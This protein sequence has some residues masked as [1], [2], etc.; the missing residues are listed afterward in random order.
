[1]TQEEA[2]L[3]LSSYKD[4]VEKAPIYII[5]ID[6]DYRITYANETFFEDFGYRRN[7]TLGL[8]ANEMGVA[9]EAFHKW[10]MYYDKV[11]LTGE[12]QSFEA[13]IEGPDGTL[14]FK[15]NLIPV[16]DLNQKVES[17]TIYLSN[18]TDSK[19][20]EDERDY[21]FNFSLDMF[22]VQT[23]E[24]NFIRLNPSWN[25]ILNLSTEKLTGANW[26]DFVHPDD[27]VRSEN[28]RNE[29]LNYNI[30]VSH[31]TRFR[32]FD[33]TYLWLEW[34]SIPIKNKDIIISVVRDITNWKEI[35]D[36]LYESEKRYREVVET[37]NYMIYSTDLKGNMELMNN[38]GLNISGFDFDELQGTNLLDLIAPDYREKIRKLYK[39]MIEKNQPTNIIE[40]PI[41]SKS[42]E[43]LWLTQNAKLRVENGVP[44]KIDFIARDITIRKDAELKLR[45]SE[46]RLRNVVNSSNEV[47]L[48]I[49]ECGSLKDANDTAYEELDIVEHELLGKEFK[50]ILF[51]NESKELISNFL[52]KELDLNSLNGEIRLKLNGKNP[53]HYRAKAITYSD[54]GENNILLFLTNITE[55]RYAQKVTEVLYSIS[56]A[57][58]LTEDLSE[59][60]KFV[61][62]EISS[63]LNAK[64][65]AVA[66]IHFKENLI[67]FPYFKDEIDDDYDSIS[68]DNEYSLTNLVIAQRRPIRIN[69]S[70]IKEMIGNKVEVY[71][72][73]SKSWLGVPLLVNDAIYGVVMV[74]DYVISDV[75]SEEDEVLLS[76]ISEILAAA[77]SK[78]QYRSEL[79]LLNKDL[80][81]R[82]AERT[83]Q[84]ETTLENLYFENDERKKAQLEL[85]KT[86][87]ELEVSLK[88]EKELHQIKTNFISMVS[89]EYRTPLTVIMSSVNLLTNYLDKM[90]SEQIDKQYKNISGSVV[91][92]TNL[93]DD[94]LMIGK[95]DSFANLNIMNFDL[96]SSISS[97][98][99][100]IQ[101]VDNG[102]HHFDIEIPEK[103]NIKSD[104]KLLDHALINLLSN[105]VKYSARD[106]TVSLKLI[107]IGDGQIEITIADQGIG[108]PEE[109]L[110][111]IFESF[112]RSSNT[113]TIEGTGLGMAIVK[114]SIDALGG[115]INIDSKVNYGTKIRIILSKN[116]NN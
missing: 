70:D 81:L 87:K 10:Y 105:A 116:I 91:S 39:K 49:G 52:N 108:I 98:L 14:F 97:I 45:S 4:I 86:K 114:K 103:L 77:I 40:F 25:E 31:E 60:Y 64:N 54:S 79:E 59:L 47:I 33:G 75:Y 34:N 106:T 72:T 102:K 93:L 76:S 68:L 16:F 44:V 61:H 48:V 55:I 113:G 67:K 15:F 2:T 19:L 36:K 101:F 95:T 38:P 92:M 65:F 96:C 78:L 58:N 115:T 24:G 21:I 71:G 109:D 26:L 35:K 37:A 104:K 53:L 7:S 88:N 43:T 22:A 73:I 29:L 110:D 20:I 111:R 74:Q 42:G 51:D 89:H 57:A 17:I 85:E 28:I 94:V 80:E 13:K 63:I 107:E 90:T 62:E 112:F 30:V 46:M 84:L 50:E 66:E 56:K 99:E 3:T 18:I 8:N 6:R 1:M 11:F 23:I 27:K 32:K 12:K 83:I 82:V 69:E 100:N 5:K 41:V 9:A